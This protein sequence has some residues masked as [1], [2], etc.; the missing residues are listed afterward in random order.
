[1]T[2]LLLDDI[3]GPILVIAPHPDDETLG[4]GGLIAAATAAGKLVHT[5]FV[6]DGSSSHRNSP[7]WPADRIAQQRQHEAA[8]ALA[9]LGAGAQPRT[10]MALKDAAMPQ[11]G[12][13]GH[14]DAVSSLAT[15][16]Q[17]LKP[18]LVLVPW[19][20]DPH[21][22]HRDSW[23][24]ITHVLAQTGITARV[25]EYTIW[26]DELGAPED[27]PVPGEVTE[28]TFSD[29][30]VVAVKRRAIAAHASQLGTLITDDPDGF[31]L[32]PATL[33][34]LIRPVEIFWQA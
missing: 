12:E 7:T 18:D 20:R 21:C 22:D 10:F 24:L 8:A 11:P 17:K 28:F 16:V 30:Q 14:A 3:K 31:H 2:Q 13:Q 27:F 29:P 33:D 26:L 5:V 4:C 6:T 15:L 1:M 9:A 19:R 25:L 32:T 23:S 34:R